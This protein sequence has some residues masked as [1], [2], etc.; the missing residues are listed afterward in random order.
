MVIALAG[1]IYM[2]LY[3]TGYQ[4]HLAIAAGAGPL[5]LWQTRAMESI[6][7]PFTPDDLWA[8][9]VH[10]TLYFVPV[11]IVTFA[12]GGVWEV[13]FS[14]VRG[15]EVNEGLLVTGMLFPLILGSGQE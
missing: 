1:C 15:H 11:L 7:L 10:G 13:L 14:V 2:A 3:N 12:V 4:A 6:G 5:D 8:C 9:L